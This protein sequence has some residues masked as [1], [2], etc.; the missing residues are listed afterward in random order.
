MLPLKLASLAAVY[1]VLES[2]HLDAESGVLVCGLHLLW[3]AKL[4]LLH[5]ARVGER[6]A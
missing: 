2:T 5:E 4:K 3:Q 1:L 6:L